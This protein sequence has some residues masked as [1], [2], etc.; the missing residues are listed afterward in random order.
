MFVIINIMST[1]SNAPPAFP[2]LIPGDST[3]QTLEV[4]SKAKIQKVNVTQQTS[5]TT[6]VIANG[7]SGTITMVASTLASQGTEAFTVN[8]S[9]CA[10]D[11]TVMVNTVAYTGTGATAVISVG[12]TAIAQGSFQIRVGNASGAPLNG[13]LSI[14]YLIV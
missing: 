10:T 4:Q 1:I 3:L 7:N 6:S 12:V 14:A 9:S 8:N 5:T 13:V 11:S 2:P